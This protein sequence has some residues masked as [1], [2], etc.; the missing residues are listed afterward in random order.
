MASI[1]F[2]KGKCTNDKKEQ[3]AF[4]GIRQGILHM[5]AKICQA[6]VD[7]DKREDFVSSLL[8]VFIILFCMDGMK[9]RGSINGGF[10]GE[11]S[12]VQVA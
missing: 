6:E 10:G 8:S 9:W 1:T 12:A 5:Q 3:A 11:N 7:N 2:N 4:R